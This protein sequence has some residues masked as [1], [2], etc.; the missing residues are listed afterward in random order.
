MTKRQFKEEFIKN[1]RFYLPDGFKDVRILMRLVKK[2]EKNLYFDT[3]IKSVRTV[4]NAGVYWRVEL[5][6]EVYGISEM[7][8]L[9]HYKTNN[10][11]WEY[12][13]KG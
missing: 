9:A 13:G 8:L 4:T 12:K 5:R 10:V 7:M 3:D 6:A 11:S 1:L 2:N